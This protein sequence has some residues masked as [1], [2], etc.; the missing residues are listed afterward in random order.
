M[1]SAGNGSATHVFGE[2]F[3]I[4]TGV[5]MLHVPYRGESLALN[6]L[7]GGQVQVVFGSLLGSLGYIRTSKLRALAVTTAARSQSLPDV[8]ALSEFVPG[9]DASGWLGLGAR[10]NTPAELV[11]KLNNEINLGLADP[12]MKAMISDMG[13]MG[14]AGSPTGFGKHISAE[15]EK[16]A[17]VIRAANIKP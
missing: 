3:K 9:Y 4:M 5:N 14:F 7:L 15:T 1:G 2:L 17:K 13:A 11:S 16:W 8:P 12:K 6:D 10:K